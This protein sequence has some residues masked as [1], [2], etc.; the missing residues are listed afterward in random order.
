M[1]TAFKDVEILTTLDKDPHVTF[2]A[3]ESDIQDIASGMAKVVHPLGLLSAVLTDEQWAA[4]PGNTTIVNAQPQIAPRF[5]PQTYV[6]I[7]NTMT[8]V[9][10]YV[11][12]AANDRTQ[13]W[14]DSTEALKRAVIK[15]LGRVI[16][17]MVR[18]PKV[19]FQ[20]MS[21]ADI[22]TKVRARYGCMQRD[23]KANLREKM[24]TMLPTTDKLDTHISDLD[25][26]F[27]VSEIAGFPIDEN[28]KMDIFRETVSGHPLILKVLETFDFEFPD[29]KACTHAQICEY[30]VLHLP[31]LKSAQATAV[32]ANAKF[33]AATAYVTLEAESKR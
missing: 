13:S 9:E 33:V 25:D 29:F 2:F 22:M 3:W 11:A 20:R 10:L 1:T 7:V 5:V 19:R 31:N 8:S 32:K 17:Q 16:R 6:D 24:L 12:K 15:S 14:I 27:E 4:Y 21:V 18:A 30:I 26:M 23:T 28:T